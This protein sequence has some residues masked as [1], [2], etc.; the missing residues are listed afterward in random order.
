[1]EEKLSAIMIKMAKTVLKNP[2][3]PHSSE[4]AHTALL[5]AN[6]AWNREVWS[7]DFQS[8]KQYMDLIKVFEKS[9]G[10]LWE[11]LKSRDCEMLIKYLRD[12]KKK[13]YPKDNRIIKSC[14]FNKPENVQITWEYKTQ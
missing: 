11:E 8:S 6:T 3:M 1:M 5:L 10:L 9:N 4:A 7:E 2:E 12:F 13:H 14:G